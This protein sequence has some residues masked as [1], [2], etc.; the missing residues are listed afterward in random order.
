MRR[1]VAGAGVDVGD[2]GLGATDRG[3][4]LAGGGER[5]QVDGNQRRAGGQGRA[6]H[7]VEKRCQSPS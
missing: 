7:H 4:R 5:G 3:R 6:S 1:H 2:G